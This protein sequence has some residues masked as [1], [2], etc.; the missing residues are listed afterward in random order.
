M[1][2]Q[3]LIYFFAC[4]QH[5]SYSRAAR[6][7]Y[8]SRQALSQAIHEMERDLGEPL[9]TSQDSNLQLTPFGQYFKLHAAGVLQE[10]N[11]L[12]QALQQWKS[13]KFNQIKIAIGLG[14]INVISPRKLTDF[15]QRYPE[16]RLNIQEYSDPKVRELVEEN[17]ADLAILSTIPALIQKFHSILIK[18]GQIY[19]Q[20]HKDHFLAERGSVT[21]EDLRG[22]PFVSLGDDC[23][24]HH[25]LVEKC[26]Q[27]G[28]QPRFVWITHDSN[29]ANNMVVTN[30][31]LSFGHI[32]TRSMASLPMIRLVPL[33]LDEEGW[34][35]YLIMKANAEPPPAVKA[36]IRS[37]TAER[38]TAGLPD[39][40]WSILLQEK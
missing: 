25:V 28:F 4:C 5:L 11:E 2:I 17:K 12:E 27:A 33:V 36:F 15:Q 26:T 40:S 31:A 18:P 19:L 22:Q 29:V 20:I 10:H 24:M 3:Q 30:A 9:F 23:D 7:L 39:H 13:Q 38:E 16:F 21:V 32:Q 37:L 14:A 35:T 1:E 34:G 8:I 6:K